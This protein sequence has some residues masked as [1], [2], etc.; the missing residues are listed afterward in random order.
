[1]AKFDW[2]RPFEFDGQIGNTA[3]GIKLIRRNDSC[4]RTG[5]QAAGAITA[6]ILDR[7]IQRQ[8]QVSVEFSEKEKRSRAGIDQIGVLP[9]PA[10][11]G[12]CLLYTSDAADE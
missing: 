1:M 5:V 6:V 3:P 8:W 2:D 4:G 7:R 12:T 11:P 10:E 9:D